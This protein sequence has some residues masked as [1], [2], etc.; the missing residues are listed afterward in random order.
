[1][2]R[3]SKFWGAKF[4]FV[5][6]VPDSEG[7]GRRVPP[8]VYAYDHEDDCVVYSLQCWTVARSLLSLLSAAYFCMSLLVVNDRACM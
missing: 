5:S 7:A 4:A 1:M 3:M 2:L 8:V 6:S